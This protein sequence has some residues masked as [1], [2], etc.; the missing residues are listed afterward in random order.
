MSEYKEIFD[1]ERIIVPEVDWEHTCETVLVMEYV[2][3]IPL[4]D[5]ES[6]KPDFD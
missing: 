6:Q 2:E 1:Q 5:F 3:G 4:T